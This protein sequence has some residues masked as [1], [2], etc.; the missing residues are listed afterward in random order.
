MRIDKL[1]ASNKISEWERNFLHNILHKENL[2]AKQQQTLD[3]IAA[4]VARPASK[5]PSSW[6]D[7]NWLNDY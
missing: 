2:T 3:R 4:K 5:Y 6:L 1:L 7:D